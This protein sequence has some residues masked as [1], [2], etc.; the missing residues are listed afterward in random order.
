MFKPIKGG[1][2]EVIY[3]HFK[4]QIPPFG[5]GVNMATGE[6]EK[7]DE[8][9]KTTKKKDQKW[10]REPLPDWYKEKRKTEVRRQKA[11]KDYVDQE[12]EEYRARE[13]QRRLCGVWVAMNGVWVYLTGLHYMYV[14]WWV[15][16]SK[17]MNYRNV[18][19]EFFNVWRYVEEDPDCL[20][21]IYITNRKSGK[22]AKSGVVE[23]EPISRTEGVHGGI[24]SMTDPEAAGVFDKAIIGPWKALPHFFKPTYDTSQGTH[25]KTELRFF[26]PSVRGAKALEDDDTPELQSFIDFAARGVKGYDGP[27]LFRYVSDECAK[28]KDVDINERHETVK[29]CTE[30]NGEFKGKFLYTTTIEEMEGGGK[31]FLDL[32]NKSNFNE[33]NANNRTISGMFVLFLP[34]Y[35]VHKFDEYGNSLDDLGKRY[36]MNEREGKKN[37]EKGLASFIR[38]NP[39]TLEEAFRVDSDTCL[40]N[41]FKLNERDQFLSWNS[42]L[43]KRGNFT[44]KD[45][46]KDSK[47]EWHEDPNGRWEISWLPEEKDWNLVEKNGGLFFPRNTAQYISASDTYDHGSTEDN[48]NSKAASFVKRRMNPLGEDGT[49]RK[50]ICKYHFRPP[51]PEMV[52]EDLIMQCFFFGCGILCESNKP[53]VLRYFL[54]RGY[55]AFLIRIPGYKE[56]GIPSTQENKREASLMVEAYIEQNI[57]KM[58]FRDQIYQLLRFDITKT[59]KWDLA[60]ATLWTEYADNYRYFEVEAKEEELIEANQFIRTYGDEES[61]YQTDQK[62]ELQWES[63][64]VR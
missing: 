60:M 38:K 33:R 15:F 36:F 19:R 30:I 8:I 9:R 4:C 31:D 26:K 22:T 39:F 45:G 64:P 41:A 53:G 29:F 56:P 35:R 21:L 54:R 16:Q 27:E 57:L 7:V 46:I 61:I 1:T 23:Y 59:T 3:E 34:A 62:A 14:Q 17:Y 37:D 63:R 52:Y 49:S 6:L 47:V 20:G 11:D 12:C 13:W 51:I 24:Q 48:R 50:Y 42:Q 43:T 32:V 58:D 25:P 5:Y 2:V 18:D 40:Y 10:E 44:W 55:D 28:L